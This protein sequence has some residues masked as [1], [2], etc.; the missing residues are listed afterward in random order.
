VI[1][2]IKII[3]IHAMVVFPNGISHDSLIEC[4]QIIIAS[5]KII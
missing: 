4:T 1:V 2:Y 5:L 3:M